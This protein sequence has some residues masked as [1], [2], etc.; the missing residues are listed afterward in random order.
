MKFK[1]SNLNLDSVLN[2]Q[3]YQFFLI[4][5]TIKILVIFNHVLRKA[6]DQKPYIQ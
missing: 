5:Y 6:G 2:F 3:S 4:I 1:I